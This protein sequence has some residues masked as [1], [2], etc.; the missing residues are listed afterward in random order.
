LKT[1]SEQNRIVCDAGWR[2]YWTQTANNGLIAT[3]IAPRAQCICNEND[4]NANV[5]ACVECA[6]LFGESNVLRAASNGIA[7]F[8]G[9]A[10]RVSGLAVFEAVVRLLLLLMSE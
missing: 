6:A 5:L 9:R 8:G 7:T 10:A 3:S 1:V 4:E 2:A